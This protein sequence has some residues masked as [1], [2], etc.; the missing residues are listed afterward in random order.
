MAGFYACYLLTPIDPEHHMKISYVGFT[1][2]P[3]RRLRQH[4]GELASGGAKY[5]RKFRPWYSSVF[6]INTCR[7]FDHFNRDMAIVVHGFPSDTQALQFEYA[8][9]R[10]H[11]SRSTKQIVQKY[12]KGKRGLGRAGAVP[13][14]IA[15]LMLML[16]TSPWIQLPLSIVYTKPGTVILS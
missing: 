15:Q 10:A 5:T 1:V 2:C 9:Q 8:W 7:A 3:S 11:K 12:L 6:Q 13:R 16:R 4:N 14:K